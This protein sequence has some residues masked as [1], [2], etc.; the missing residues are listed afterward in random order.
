MLLLWQ[1][2]GGKQMNLNTHTEKALSITPSTLSCSAGVTVDHR[3]WFPIGRMD[4]DLMAEIYT[5]ATA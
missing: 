2:V 1:L 4:I 3:P 5:V